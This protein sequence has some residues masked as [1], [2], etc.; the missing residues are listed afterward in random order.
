MA[1]H[2]SIL[3]WKI[4][5]TEDPGRLQSM[6]LQSQIQLSDSITTTKDLEKLK[7]FFLQ[8]NCW[9]YKLRIEK[10]R[11]DKK[12]EVLYLWCLCLHLPQDRE[13]TKPVLEMS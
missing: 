7:K 11:W 4:L 13:S 2:S 1:T 8:L 10:G 6:E 5:W 9:Y 3:A 12:G